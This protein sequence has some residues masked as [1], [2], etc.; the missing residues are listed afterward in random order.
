MSSTKEALLGIGLA[1]ILFHIILVIAIQSFDD[2][3]FNFFR[4][5]G[6]LIVGIFILLIGFMESD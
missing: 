5:F 2:V 6:I 1:L 3:L 4:D